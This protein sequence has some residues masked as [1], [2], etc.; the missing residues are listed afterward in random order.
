M[1]LNLI[2]VKGCVYNE[3]YVDY[4]RGRRRSSK[5]YESK[6]YFPVAIFKAPERVA[7]HDTMP[8]VFQD[9]AVNATDTSGD[10][11]T[12]KAPEKNNLYTTASPVGSYFFDRYK[13]GD[14]VTVYYYPGEIED[15]KV[16]AF[17]TYWLPLPAIYL[18][19]ML[20]FLWTA[21]CKLRALI[22][23]DFG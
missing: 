5:A 15:A 8:K 11:S 23:K 18:L 13:P 19:A 4:G 10:S 1:Y 9:M 6:S 7:S 16:L 17:S 14:S 21:A 12:V 3:Y 22:K 2:L 20:C